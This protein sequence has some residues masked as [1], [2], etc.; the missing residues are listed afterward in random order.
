MT[1]QA[2]DFVERFL[3]DRQGKGRVLKKEL[4]DK[5]G[6]F[7]RVFDEDWPK[8]A[9]DE[10]QPFRAG[11]AMEFE[12]LLAA[13]VPAPDIERALVHGRRVPIDAEYF[14]RLSAGAE[15]ADAPGEAARTR[16]LIDGAF[17]AYI[18][19]SFRFAKRSID[20]FTPRFRASN[21][22]V[23]RLVARAFSSPDKAP[24]IRVLVT[25]AAGARPL[26]GLNAAASALLR[27]LQTTR[28]THERMVIVDGEKYVT[29]SHG[30]TP[31]SLFNS[32][33]ISVGVEQ[34]PALLAAASA[35]FEALWASGVRI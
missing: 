9:A 31:T 19:H 34:S 5:L 27:E 30:F 1:D 16:L 10:G 33:E 13:E 8:E 35:R 20:I 15:I 22:A 21:R 26:R 14:A 23:A 32:R 2:R 28:R 17:A 12:A 7:S 29:G 3:K 4:Q 6:T 25:D 18:R 24:R 11:L